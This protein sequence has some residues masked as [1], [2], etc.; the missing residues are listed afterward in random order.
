MGKLWWVHRKTLAGE[1][2]PK[3]REGDTTDR[4]CV[5]GYDPAMD[6]KT[7][8]ACVG[9]ELPVALCQSAGHKKESRV[10]RNGGCIWL[11]GW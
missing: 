5:G 11:Q 3:K 9:W 7:N 4:G 8:V 10:R 6:E 2:R 1:A